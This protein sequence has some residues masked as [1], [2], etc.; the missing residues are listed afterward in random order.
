MTPENKV[1]YDVKFD[2][3]NGPF[4]CRSPMF[5]MQAIGDFLTT[6]H[7]R[8]SWGGDH[9][10]SHRLPH[11]Y[12]PGARPLTTSFG[13]SGLRTRTIHDYLIST[14][15]RSGP[16]DYAAQC[17]CD[18]EPNFSVFAR[19]MFQLSDFF[20]YLTKMHGPHLAASQILKNRFACMC[21][22]F[23]DM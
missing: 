17:A 12:P 20:C 7:R 13:E 8:N 19:R 5:A 16:I 1:A 10:D 3:L 2:Q 21:Y 15:F 18:G 14:R 9:P 6:Y 11:T 22:N 23:V 4:A